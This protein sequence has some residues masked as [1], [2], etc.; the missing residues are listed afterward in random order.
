[1]KVAFHIAIFP[2]LREEWDRPEVLGFGYLAAWLRRRYPDLDIILADTEEDL[3]AA[4]ADVVGLTCVTFTYGR[5]RQIARRLRERTG[6]RIVLGGP[7]VT[8]L[9]ERMD[10]EFDFGVLG[11]GEETLTA[12][13]GHLRASEPPEALASIE[14]LAFWR[15]G[16]R[17]INPR[18]PLIEPID[19]IP[20]PDRRIYRTQTGLHGGNVSIMTSRG[21]PYDCSF[22]ASTS[23]WQRLRVHSADYVL[24]ELDEVIRRYRPWQ[25]V[26]EDDLFIADRR[27]LSEIA[28]GILRRG[29]H[30]R[31]RFLVSARANLLTD[32]V[33]GVLRSINTRTV[34]VGLESACDH[35]LLALGKKNI[36]AQTNQ[37]AL[38]NAAR[39]GLKVIGTFI[40]GTPGE[41]F[42]DLQETYCFVQRNLG[43][44]QKMSAGVLRLLP[45]TPFWEQGM[46]R[47][48]ID[49]RMTG[50]VFDERDVTDGWY[51]LNHRYPMLCTT[52][53]RNELLAMYL[54]FKELSNFIRE[55]NEGTRNID[56]MSGR[57]IAGELLRRT[58]RRLRFRR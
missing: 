45:G 37:Q 15:E 4:R 51:S 32:D 47:G 53:T 58:L 20:C 10:E 28:E 44:F 41:T 49:D 5:A 56:V 7:H 50:I 2:A 29:H 18:R 30:R 57:K 25:V 27:R 21:C 55:R 40:L 46:K 26:F 52:M 23:H 1:L 36:T 8:A 12:L 43:V 16:R 34:F 54:V 35:V 48:L 38:D 19:Q 39:H 13:I 9:P 31:T 24:E 11:E 3:L 17:V 42:D 14:G 33:C 6:A 22:C